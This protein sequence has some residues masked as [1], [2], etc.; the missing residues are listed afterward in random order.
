MCSSP[1]SQSLIETAAGCTCLTSGKK[2][3]NNNLPLKPK[4]LL[5][6]DA[7]QS[8]ALSAQTPDALAQETGSINRHQTKN[9]HPQ[10]IQRTR[11]ALICMHLLMDLTFVVAKWLKHLA[12]FSCCGIDCKNKGSNYWQDY[13]R[14]K[15]SGTL[16]M[17]EPTPNP[18]L[19]P[20]CTLWGIL[21][22]W[23]GQ[24]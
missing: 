16:K 12:Y 22:R 2:N 1:F 4:P 13:L 20:S 17:M 23:C 8:S 6:C 14:Q 5:I 3:K 19:N 24:I 18:D 9:A 15:E 11:T 21:D 7:H 10:Q